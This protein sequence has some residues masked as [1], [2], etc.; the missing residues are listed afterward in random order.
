MLVAVVVVALAVVSVAIAAR[1][2]EEETAGRG[3]DLTAI[4]CPAPAGGPPEAKPAANAFNTAEL[5]GLTLAD[6][7]RKAARHTCEVIVSVEDGQG[8]PVPIT[9]DP[10]RIYVYTEKGGVTEVEGVG[11]GI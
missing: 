5:I 10:K 7:R 3:E 6:A 9:E 1:G 4:M 2:G 11:G 8:R